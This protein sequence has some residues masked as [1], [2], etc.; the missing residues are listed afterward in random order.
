VSADAVLLPLPNRRE[1]LA[2][3][4]LQSGAVA[5]VLAVSTRHAFELDR[6]FVPKELVLH[7]AAL[8]AGVLVVRRV[9]LLLG[10][11]LFAGVL[12][13]AFAT[14][15]WL[16]LRALAISA[17]GILLM[18]AARR[19]ALAGLSRPLLRALAAAVVLI[20]ITSLLQTYGLDVDLF[21]PNRAPGGTLGNRNFVA[22]AAAFGLPL[23]LLAALGARTRGAYLRW[24]GGA[25]LVTAS[26][27]L[28]RSR[29]AWLAHGA[30]VL[31]VFVTM[32]LAPALRRDRRTWLRLFGVVLIAGAGVAAALLLPNTLHWR[33]D[34]P[35]LESVQRVT[36]YQQGSGHG[37]L[38]QY[39]QSLLMAAR[40]PLLG[41][42]PG[43]WAV[44][45]PSHAARRDPSLS[46][47][48]GGMTTN[49]W[50]SSDWIAFLAE[51]GLGA[52]MLLALVF[53]FIALGAFRQ[54]RLS[55]DAEHALHAVALI[56]L[57]LGTG[58][59][60]G[61]DA[62]LLLGLPTLLVWTAI[63][64]L[65]TPPPDQRFLPRI[66]AAAIIAIAALGVARSIAQLTAMEIYA[67]SHD[68]ASL[69]RAAGIDPG[70][71]RVQLRLARL[72]GRQRCEHARAAHALFPSAD[73]AAALSRRCR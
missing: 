42:G 12:S 45:Y 70:N 60:G 9:D 6:F 3:R 69:E 19:L 56:G 11:Y 71:Y 39:E 8:L 32:L 41:V 24:A 13:A 57:L 43:N 54:L 1:R 22:H 50:P 48:D 40:H 61:L 65:W 62:V 46:D 36:D 15:R 68:R 2:L 10:L 72:G 34:N 21:S 25:S 63:G 33:S 47:T 37:R 16:G 64:A 51:R 29:A 27:V 23:V 35:Y 30:V 4:V 52:T 67:T 18:M 7:A 38:I 49:P 20:A 55:L 31:V 26:L 58:I 53:L 44:E 66:A 28:T 14:N 17:S 59:T 5:V 73:E